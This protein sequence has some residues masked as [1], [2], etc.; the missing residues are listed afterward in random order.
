MQSVLHARMCLLVVVAIVLIDNLEI[1]TDAD[2]A[3][4]RSVGRETRADMFLRVA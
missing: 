3:D 1:M 2:F 4:W